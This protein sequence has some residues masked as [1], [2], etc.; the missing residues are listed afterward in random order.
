MKKVFFFLLSLAVFSCQT[1]SEEKDEKETSS[2]EI[3]ESV[4]DEVEEE[5]PKLVLDTFGLSEFPSEIDGCAC[6]FKEKGKG[7]IYVDDFS[8]TAFIKVNGSFET[9]ELYDVMNAEGIVKQKG[10]SEHYGLDMDLKEVS[11]EDETWQYE[12]NIKVDKIDGSK[13]EYTVVGE[14]GC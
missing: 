11:H 9:L 7:Y 4:E 1:M 3:M 5:S 8:R 6:Y 10:R 14:C 2:P 13:N 12:G